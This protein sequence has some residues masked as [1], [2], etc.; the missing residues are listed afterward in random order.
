MEIMEI[1][2]YM[3]DKKKK[4]IEDAIF[5]LFWLGATAFLVWKARYGFADRD[6]S[7][8]LT[9]PRRIL[10]GDAILVEEWHVSQLSGILL[11]PIMAVYLLINP[12]AVGMMLHFRFI[13]VAFQA[14]TSLILYSR[15]KRYSQI[16]GMMGALIFMIYAP[17]GI[18][19]LSYNS[20]GVA[21]FALSTVLFVTR[22]EFSGSKQKIY[23]GYL[24]DATVGILFSAA[25]LC[26]PYLAV[27]YFIYAIC[28]GVWAAGSKKSKLT[29][30]IPSLSLSRLFG[31]TLGVAVSV[32]AFL[33]LLLSRTDLHT[34]MKAIPLILSDPEHPART[35]WSTVESFVWCIRTS[36]SSAPLCYLSI[37]I[38]MIAA[39]LDRQSKARKTLYFVLAAAIS[40]VYA[41]ELKD[42]SFI[43][44]MM[45]PLNLVGAVSFF[46]LRKRPYPLFF[47][48][49]LPTVFF[50]WAISATSNQGFLVISSAFSVGTLVSTIFVFMFVGEFERPEPRSILSAVAATVSCLVVLVI[51][52]E[53]RATLNF[54]DGKTN[55][56]DYM[57][58]DGV[59]RGVITSE[60]NKI[61]WERLLED[62]AE[63]RAIEDGNVLYFSTETAMYLSDNKR[64][65]AF[66]SWISI[67]DKEEHQ[68]KAA[69]D[70]LRD[71]YDLC[72]EKFPDYIYVDIKTNGTLDAIVTTFELSDYEIETTKYGNTVIKINTGTQK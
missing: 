31:I 18:S 58:T 23:L 15:L 64:S 26:Q 28:V 5:L 61:R 69:I 25:V 54:W 13:Y 72:P 7:F 22:P 48:V 14:I 32:M 12:T 47:G 19:A 49:W 52:L 16:G 57:I 6:E 63:L 50:A 33:L 62:T 9:I 59:N 21:L 43:N 60:Y 37:G 27:L 20:M 2:E 38:L 46:L 65:S 41:I 56:L 67:G 30:K 42:W 34:L 4:L 55:T 8:Y 53:L 10:Q 44:C 36:S 66:S 35:L 17:F 51:G 11:V 24:Y 40:V 71:Y 45:M 68:I 29:Q 70:R 1:E 3:T 39:A